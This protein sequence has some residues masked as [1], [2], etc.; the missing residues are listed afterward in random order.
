M[1]LLSAD[2][3]GSLLNLSGV[4]SFSSPSYGY[5]GG[6][7]G[8]RYSVIASTGGVVDL[9]GVG[10]ITGARDD[11]STDPNWIASRLR[12]RVETGGELRLPNLVQTDGRTLFEI[13][14]P[15]YA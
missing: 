13:R 12:F 2:G 6:G 15:S 7:N 11:F 4:Q 5:E 1:T 10:S 14:V 3:V 9:S 8:W